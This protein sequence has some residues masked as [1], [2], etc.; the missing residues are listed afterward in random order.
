MI[1]FRVIVCLIVFALPWLS[2]GQAIL[3]GAL[4]AKELKLYNDAKVAAQKG[5]LKKSNAK[6][7]DLLKSQPQFVE[8]ILRLAS[9]H[10][11]AKDY[12]K[13][14]SLFSSAITIDPEFDTE[15]YYSMAMSQ[16]SQNKYLAAAISFDEYI[17][18]EKSKND[19]IAKATSL[20]DNL[21]FK[22]HALKNP[23]SFEP[24]NLGPNINSSYLEYS[25]SIAVDGSSIIFTRN[26]QHKNDFIGQ[27]DFYISLTDSLGFRPATPIE[28]LNTDGNEGAFALSSNGKYIVFTACDRKDAFGGCD[29]YYSMFMNDEWTIPVNMGHKVNSA[30]WDS[31]PTLSADGRTLYF[32][33]NRKG[34]IGAADIWMTYRN[35]NNA[36]V[37]PI[38]LGP[39][40]NST[41]SDETPFLHADGQTLYFRSN[42][43][44][45]MGDF[46]IYYSRKDLTTNKWT[47]PQNIG[48]PI[49][50]EGAE[51]SFVVSV[52]GETAYFA[53]DV[54]YKTGEKL[55]QLD[56][57]MAKLYEKAR[58]RPSNYVK[59]T[60]RD[61]NSGQLL[62]STVIIKNL[63]LNTEVFK[64]DTD[65]DGFFIT[66]ITAGYNYACIVLKD[67]YVYYTKNFDLT[68]VILLPEPYRLDIKLMPIINTTNDTVSTPVVLQNIFF[69]TGS[70][71]LLPTSDTEIAL[72]TKMMN[73]SPKVKILITGHT[74]NVGNDEANMELSLNRAKSVALALEK[75]GID[76]SRIK[77]EGKGETIPRDTNDT[78]QGRQNNR[79]TEFIILK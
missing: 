40:I 30:G 56:L 45:G 70:A 47:E 5:D 44:P 18:R 11:T 20:R 31:Q 24:I 73:E 72:L 63:D 32:S 54:D 60:I 61:I 74:D 58:P 50:T 23:V 25:P 67:G 52:D 1:T 9:N 37:T 15:M 75:S 33:S 36:W 59:G 78:P 21:R 53:S 14:E 27:E 62:K 46:D 49:N 65:D 76:P 57:Y 17:K 43:R 8:G 41:G 19:K 64:F 22:D 29:L 26:I 10:F 71:E 42:G 69:S 2:S 66:G 13:A 28:S 38:N 34:S 55:H 48:Y 79:R 77:Y 3:K 51:G 6:F 68:E 16:V 12:A 4:N 35:E 39:E 7:T